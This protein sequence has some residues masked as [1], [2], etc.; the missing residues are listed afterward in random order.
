MGVARA[1]ALL[2]DD[3]PAAVPPGIDL[4]MVTYQVGDALREVGTPPFLTA[5]QR[6]GG[7]N[8]WAVAG[9]RAATGGPLLAAD[10]HR[11]LANPALRYLVH[12]TAPGW[13]VAGATAPWLPGVAIGHN[14]RVAWG[15]TAVDADTADL[16]VERLNPDNSHQVEIDGRWQNTTVVAGTISVK[17]RDKPIAFEREYTPHGVVI[18]TDKER[19][20]AF[21]LRWSGHEPGGAA[22]LAALALDRAQSAAG[23]RE[24]LAH[25]KMP[26]VE[27]V[28]ADRGGGIGSQVAAHVPIRR[29]WDGRLPAAGWLSGTEWTGWRTLDEPS[30][31]APGRASAAAPR[32]AGY[33]ASANGNRARTERLRSVLSSGSFSIEAFAKLQHDVR[34]WNAERLL[35]LL[36]RMRGREAAVEAARQQLL[37]WDREVSTDSAPAALYVT[38]ERVVKRM[39]VEGRVPAPL[40]D[41]FVARSPNMLVPALVTPSRVWFDGDVV[42]AGDELVARALAAAVA[43]LAASGAPDRASATGAIEE[44]LLAHPL[45]ITA[46][47]RQRF[48]VGPFRRSRYADML[49]STSGQRP[50]TAIGASFAAIF[51]TSDW[52]RSIVQN[53]P[54][55]SESP[56]SAHFADL[57][58]LWS[59]QQYFPLAFSEGAVAAITESTLTLQPI[60]SP[61][62]SRSS[63]SGK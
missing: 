2:G 9:G 59:E 37:A 44:V 55:Q 4:A 26:S 12:L 39:L 29:G 30:S 43:E 35:P 45:A 21:A 40:V 47:A 6:Q 5:L 13:N 24:A 14:D 61:Q 16:Y 22:E 50:E 19:Q 34:A 17:G 52:D 32:N 58:T 56:A 27:V 10:P 25:W 11:L 23:V 20:L 42:R 7:S 57:A 33:V 15:M 18:G 60:R 62:R 1:A 49:M 38:W 31:A 8:A 3:A 48:N 41:D 28:Y 46:A 54:G 51:D 63:Q 36:T 53:A